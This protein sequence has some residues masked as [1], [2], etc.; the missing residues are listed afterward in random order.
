MSKKKINYHELAKNDPNFHDVRARV[1]LE[2]AQHLKTYAQ[3]HSG[4]VIH[5]LNFSPEA[6]TG[7]LEAAAELRRMASN[8]R[9][10]HKKHQD[11]LRKQREAS[12]AKAKAFG[13]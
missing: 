5:F 4:P 13:Q 12:E 8:A 10:A 1:L 2:A 3:D 7:I 9:R 6:I 11:G